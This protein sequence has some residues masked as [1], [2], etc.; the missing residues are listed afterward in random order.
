MQTEDYDRHDALG[1]ANLIRRGEVSAFEVCET[2]IARIEALNP[3]LNAIVAQRF[4]R[5]CSEARKVAPGQDRI[6][7][8]VPILLKDLI[9]Q[10]CDL[11]TTEGTRLLAHRRPAQTS[12]LTLRMEAAG[13][14]VLG[15]TNTPE[16]G[17]STTTE[18]QLFG[19]CRNPGT[20]SALPAAAPAA[21]PQRSR[22]AWCRSR[23][24]T[25]AEAR[26]GS[27]RVVAAS[28]ASSR[29]GGAIP[30]L[31]VRFTASPAC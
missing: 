19:P 21:L 28:S 2:A 4:D 25:M 14:I 27:L 15:K 24:A 11:P 6:F 23:T 29:A 30:P 9:Q 8:G 16:L 3:A 5:A 22:Q 7:A 12:E 26:S 1:L 10:H 17:L 31:P 13:A 18:P 20:L